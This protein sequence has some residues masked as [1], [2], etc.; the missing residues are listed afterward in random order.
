[1]SERDTAYEDFGRLLIGW[2]QRA[3]GPRKISLLGSGLSESGVD[4]EPI[5]NPMDDVG[6]M[7]YGEEGGVFTTLPAP[8]A[9]DQVLG[10]TGPDGEGKY[11]P[12]WTPGGV[13]TG[14]YRSVLYV[15]D[16]AGG[17]SF[18]VDGDGHPMY[19]LRELE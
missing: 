18:V 2:I 8:T 3:Q 7:V 12:Q 10:V 9:V 19:T 1:M 17:F 14:L 16:G 5:D 4:S 11:R 6:Q 15:L 13:G